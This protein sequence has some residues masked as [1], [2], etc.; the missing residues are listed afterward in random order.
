MA[1]IKI[2]PAMVRQYNDRQIGIYDPCI[3]CR[4]NY[5]TC[6]HDAVTPDLIARIKKLGKE[7]RA[8]VLRS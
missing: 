8:R 1:E 2:T 4:G 3:I 7:G 6:G 5:L